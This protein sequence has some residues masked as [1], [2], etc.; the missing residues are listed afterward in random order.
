MRINF[1]RSQLPNS[2]PGYMPLYTG[3]FNSHGR[4][5]SPAQ[6]KV[7]WYR[8][9]KV[10]DGPNP[11]GRKNCNFNKKGGNQTARK[12]QPSTVIFVPTPGEAC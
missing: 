8:N 4:T 7:N 5:K 3:S 10:K 9:K 11:A 12:V 1:R 2:S 6:K